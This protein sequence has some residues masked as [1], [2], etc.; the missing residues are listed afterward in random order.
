MAPKA[1]D[2]LSVDG[3]AAK[4]NKDNASLIPDA[5]KIHLGKFSFSHA[6]RIVLYSAHSNV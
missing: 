1:T 3:G 6:R 4:S 5:G 2:N